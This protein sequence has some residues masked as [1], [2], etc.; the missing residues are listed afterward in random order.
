VPH[1]R[2]PGLYGAFM[3]PH[4]LGN[5]GHDLYF[6]MSLWPAYA[7]FWMRATLGPGRA[8]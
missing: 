3:E 4:F 5:G 8:S 1:A 7:V 6:V 2:F